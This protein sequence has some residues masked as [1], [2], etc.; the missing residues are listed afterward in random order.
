MRTGA[1]LALLVVA[2][3]A[4]GGSQV[5]AQH[6]TADLGKFLPATLEAPRPHQGD[7]RTL[8]VRVYADAAVRANAKWKDELADQLDYASQ[9]LVPL[10]GV[11]LVVDEVKPWDRGVV[12]ADEAPHAPLDALAALDKG[13]DVAF[14]VGYIAPGDRAS[15]VLADVVDARPL[16]PHVIV[17]AWAEKP[18]TER[19]ARALPA[20]LK[21]G[22][23]GEVL[24][25]HAR[26]HQTV[27]LVHGLAIT[28][29]A[30][31]EVDPTW[32]QHPAYSPKQSTFS[33]RNRELMEL[34][35]GALVAHDE[36]KAI[37]PKLLD[38][39]EKVDYGGWLAPSHDEVVGVLR[40]VIEHGKAGKTASDIP[41]A[42]SDEWDRI[43][44]LRKQHPDDPRDALAELD[45]LLAAYPANAAMHQLKCD[46]LLVKPG[47]GDPKTT[48]ACARVIELAPGDP[49]IHLAVGLALA[50]GAKDAKAVAAAH[51]ELAK[52]E[53]K[54]KNLP[55]ADDIAATWHQ[56]VELYARM[57]ALTWTEDA[58]AAA[59]AAHVATAGWPEI[60]L[61][62]QNR[63][64][65]GVPRDP[66]VVAPEAEGF[67]LA[68][69]QEALRLVNA[70]KFGDA[71]RALAKAEKTWPRAAGLVGVRCDLAFRQNRFDEARAR[72]RRALELMP[73]ESWALYLAGVIETRDA[74][75]L[76]RGIA[77]LE[78]AIAADPELGPAYR[79]LAKAYARAKHKDALAAL[80]QAYQ[81]KFGSPLP[82][83]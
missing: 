27:A 50:R 2:G 42:A 31:E 65:Y 36:P 46:I 47:V 73:D 72:C 41:P 75:G 51:A 38:A 15:K 58:L 29:A 9:L 8:H 22:E 43:Q 45:N 44:T 28:M 19:I 68:A 32:L 48:A 11:K 82:G 59:A 37:A 76:E 60:A 54:I 35:A 63:A 79:T 17:R 61:T 80:A 10:I 3:V 18:E 30:I 49:K 62:A 71:E 4:C 81:A 40:R 7:P 23:R 55:T 52:A 67:L 24:A 25:A 21:D 12:P 83:T 39:I 57:G 14:V 69:T 34:A 26:H 78:K 13:D 16:A 33:D 5:T 1:A 64:R 70:A 53:P 56:L 77:K 74:G 66:K 6:P 20:D